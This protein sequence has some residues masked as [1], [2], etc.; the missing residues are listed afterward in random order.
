MFANMAPV[1]FKETKFLDYPVDFRIKL[2]GKR[3]F[4]SNKTFRGFFF[5]II[6][7]IITVFIQKLLF[8]YSYSCR[9]ISFID[10]SAH[11]FILLGFLMGF[12]A[13]FG[14]LVESL[15]KRRFNIKPGKPWVPWDQLDFVIG[16]LAFLA[17]IYIPQWQAVVTLLIIVPLLHIVLNRLGYHTKVTKTKW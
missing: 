16:S 7:S 12:G 13:L 4:G 8:E 3:L 14:D 2:R 9:Y 1:F 11:N 5:G 17:I 6:V 10:Y 15:I